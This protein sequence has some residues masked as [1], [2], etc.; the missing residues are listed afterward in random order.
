MILTTFFFSLCKSLKRENKA[1]MTTLKTKKDYDDALAATTAFNLKLCPMGRPAT[2]RMLTFE[3]AC[4]S[5]VF[6][7]QRKFSI[8]PEYFPKFI[9]SI[10]KTQK[11]HFPI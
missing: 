3:S 11:T 5:S 2:L 8:S 9:D 7:P 10:T 1:R 4:S 6:G